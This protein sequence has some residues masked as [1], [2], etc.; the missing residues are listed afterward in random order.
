[1]KKLI[2]LVRSIRW[3]EIAVR[4]GA[5]LIAILIVSPAFNL[6][7]GTRI[8]QSFIAFFFL[9]AHGYT[10]NEW[11]GYNFDKNDVSKAKT[12]L[13][14]GHIAHQE[15]LILAI[16]FAAISIIMYSLLDIKFLFI[17]VFDIIMGYIYVYPKI[18]LKNVPIVSF[19]ILFVVS[20]ND[21]LLGWLIF[22][23]DISRGLLIGIYFGIL[24]ITGQHFHEAGDH[25]SDKKANVKTNAVRFGKKNIFIIGFIFY[26]LSLVYFVI[27]T[28]T[29]VV[30]RYL[31]II[32]VV[33]YPIYIAI[34]YSCLTSGIDTLNVHH[35]VRKYRL[36]Y[37][38]IGLCFIILL[39]FGK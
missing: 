35:F 37:G 36:L 16:V 39:L 19:V 28:L 12:P 32:L 10:F 26:T 8:I 5:P 9:W 24:G 30:P 31:Y 15:L 2:Y 22:S 38:I 6:S 11:G 29:G 25:D 18:L 7:T 33:T 27:L 4:T 20:I 14:A 3:F 1:M 34:F 23:P 17:V 21:F 13:L